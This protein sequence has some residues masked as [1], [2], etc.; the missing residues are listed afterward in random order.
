MEHNTTKHN[1]AKCKKNK[2]NKMQLN[3]TQNNTPKINKNTMKY[4]TIRSN[5]MT[6]NKNKKFNT[7]QPPKQL[8]QK[9]P[10]FTH[11]AETD[12]SNIIDILNTSKI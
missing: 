8:L 1:E 11:M 9:K 12:M 2:Q 6:H 7:A 5:T 10:K 3:I 4:N